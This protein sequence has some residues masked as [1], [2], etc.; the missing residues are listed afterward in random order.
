MRLLVK[1][2]RAQDV[3]GLVN[4]KTNA[5]SFIDRQLRVISGFERQEFDYGQALQAHSRKPMERN[6]EACR[7]KVLKCVPKI[8]LEEL[9]R[10]LLVVG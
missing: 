1:Q 10:Q 6:V 2:T 3:G 8:V 7:N 4:D 5:L 9:D